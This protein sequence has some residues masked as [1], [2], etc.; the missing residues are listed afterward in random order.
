[1]WLSDAN[2]ALGRGVITARDA[3]PAERA[4]KGSMRAAGLGGAAKAKKKRPAKKK[5]S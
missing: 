3:P 5:G 2:R 4:V 1:M